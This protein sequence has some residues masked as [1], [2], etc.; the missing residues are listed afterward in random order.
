MIKR[1]NKFSKYAVPGAFGV[2]II[3]SL[4]ASAGDMQQK[5][6]GFRE[7]SKRA[8]V[9]MFNQVELELSNESIKKQQAISAERVKSFG[10]R[11]MVNASGSALASLRRSAQVTNRGVKTPLAPGN[12]V[13]GSNGETGIIQED[14]SI[15]AIAAGR[16]EYAQQALKRVRGA[17]K[18]FYYHAKSEEK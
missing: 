8:N 17:G 15:G 11:V 5:T 1:R 18:V 9:D 7:M 14:G 4:I 12:C 10:C 6:Q 16:P 13:L 2:A 3:A